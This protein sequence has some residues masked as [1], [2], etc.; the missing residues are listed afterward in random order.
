MDRAQSTTSQL[1][2]GDP[3][4]SLQNGTPPRKIG[5][6]LRELSLVTFLNRLEHFTWAWYNLPV[7]TGGLA[8]LLSPSTQPHTFPGLDTIGKCVYIW[9]LFLFIVITLCIVYR[10]L[11]FPGT[12][13]SS[14]THPTESLFMASGLL[15]VASI[16]VGIAKYG[17]PSCGPWLITTY[18][19]LFWIYFAVNF[20]YSVVAYCVLFTN[21]SLKIQDMTPAWDLPIFPFMLSGTIAAAGAHQQPPDHAVPMV[22]AGTTAQGLGCW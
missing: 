5:G 12:F 20:I 8:L 4:H 3:R 18:R 22:V 14:L 17:I 15:S 6:H 1:E 9:D 21:P 2:F 19:V 13:S 10:F 11:H 16:I 7:A